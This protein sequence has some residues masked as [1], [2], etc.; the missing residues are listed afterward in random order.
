MDGRTPRE[1]ARSRKALAPLGKIDRPAHQT[2][3]EKIIG[4][5]DETWLSW[6]GVARFQ[7]AYGAAT[8]L[9]ARCAQTKNGRIA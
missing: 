2:G 8:R 3:P 5:R 9:C 6:Q 7:Q 1:N 4:E